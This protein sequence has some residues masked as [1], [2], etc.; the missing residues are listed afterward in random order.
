MHA[1]KFAHSHAQIRMQINQIN[2]K[3]IDLKLSLDHSQV[4]TICGYVA[5]V[6][7]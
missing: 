5:K 1:C 6:Y 3:N 2:L 7:I 4:E